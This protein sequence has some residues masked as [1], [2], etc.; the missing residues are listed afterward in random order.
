MKNKFLKSMSKYLNVKLLGPTW[1]GGNL[2]L[3]TNPNDPTSKVLYAFEVENGNKVEF[4]N[5]YDGSYARINNYTT[6][7]GGVQSETKYQIDIAMDLVFACFCSGIILKDGKE[8]RFTHYAEN[9]V[10]PDEH[11]QFTLGSFEM[12]MYKT[13]VEI[14]LPNFHPKIVGKFKQIPMVGAPNI[15]WSIVRTE[16]PFLYSGID[17]SFGD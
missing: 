9:I 14:R 10:K 6:I 16:R 13:Q 11:A 8:M 2:Y 4:V 17:D 15:D 3:L 12:H 5:V 7:T 1:W